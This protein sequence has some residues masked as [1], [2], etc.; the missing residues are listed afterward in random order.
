LRAENPDGGHV[1]TGS[2]GFTRDLHNRQIDSNKGISKMNTDGQAMALA[3]QYGVAALAKS[4]LKHGPM[5]I[6]ESDFIAAGKAIHGE[7][8]FAQMLSD[9]N[10]L[11]AAAK[12]C[13]QVGVDAYNAKWN[14]V[15]YQQMTVQQADEIIRKEWPM[16]DV[17][18]KTVYGTGSGG[19]E[20]AIENGKELLR[21]I[22]EEAP[23]LSPA[24]VRRRLDA[25]LEAKRQI[26][27]AEAW[28]SG[29]VMQHFQF[30]PHLKFEPRLRSTVRDATTRP[31]YC[32]SNLGRLS[33]AEKPMMDPSSRYG[34]ISQALFE[35]AVRPVA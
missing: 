4:I 27:V 24:E 22:A 16:V 28:L 14:S 11:L 29:R 17:K 31:T 8:E 32:F 25:M 13:W 18:P 30:R 1:R 15:P 12:A 19:A 10:E 34:P 33:E 26:A 35:N 20:E 23:W 6:S 2:S 3:K 9:D 5:G 7:R 21:Q